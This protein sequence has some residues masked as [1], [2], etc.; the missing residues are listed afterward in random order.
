MSNRLVA[1]NYSKALM[2]YALLENKL[3]KIH[4][5][6]REFVNLI[7]KD[8]LKSLKNPSV[9]SKEIINY[10]EEMLRVVNISADKSFINFLEIIVD[11]KRVG[12]IR[13]IYHS[14]D[15]L[16]KKN[17]KILTYEL[18][19]AE[20][21]RNEKIQEIKEMLTE[22]NPGYEIDVNHVIRK[23]ILGGFQLKIGSKI[24][25][26]SVKTKLYNL[27]KFLLN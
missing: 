12:E 23:D 1:K 19:T 3:D 20:E 9:S 25:D 26:S 10:F 21:I 7:N 22:S 2:D 15:E 27:K 11:N 16:V 24:I 5:N 18:V 6:F 17:N 14:F 8:L 13:N 4:I